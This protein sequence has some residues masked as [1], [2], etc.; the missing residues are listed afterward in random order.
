M[1][2]LLA[3]LASSLA[4]LKEHIL[5]GVDP[6]DLS[7]RHKFLFQIW[8]MVLISYTLGKAYTVLGHQVRKKKD[9]A[10]APLA[11]RYHT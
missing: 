3:S 2:A 1:C 6:S 11:V 8:G 5:D 7:L 4:P 10:A 9:L